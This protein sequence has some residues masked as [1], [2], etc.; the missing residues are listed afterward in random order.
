MPLHVLPLL[1]ITIFL[2]N[3][4]LAQNYPQTLCQN[5]ILDLQGRVGTP[6]VMLEY[7][8]GQI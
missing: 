4:N 5:Q 3:E 8:V 7:L 1:L 6:A 2:G